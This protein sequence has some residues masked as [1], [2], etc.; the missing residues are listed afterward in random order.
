MRSL[1][2][3]NCVI[4]RAPAV[5][6]RITTAGALR[7]TVDMSARQSLRIGTG[8]GFSGD[9]IEPAVALAERGNIDFLVLECLAERTIALAQ[10]ERLKD[11]A[12]GFDP[13]LTERMEALL[14]PCRS[15]KIR[16]VTNSGAAHP[17]A[18]ARAA[19]EVARRLGLH[20]M[21]VAA[22]TG[23]D[24]LEHIRRHCGDYI[25][26]YPDLARIESRIISANVYL[27]AEPIARALDQG[28]DVVITGRVADPALFLAPLIH[29]FR[30]PLDDWP[31]LGKGI[32]TGHLMECA[33]Q[34]T[35]GYF[36]DPPLCT[37][38]DLAE[39]GFPIAEVTAAGA[40]TFS[41]V[42]GTG[43][44]LN[45]ATCTEQLLYEVHDPREYVTPDVVADFS[46]VRFAQAAPNVVTAEG[47]SGAPRPDRLK[48]VAAYLD[49]YIGEGQLSYAGP[50][51][52]A[53]ASL[54]L[55]IVRHRLKSLGM[56]EST[57]RFELI[58]VDSVVRTTAASSAP[59]PREVRI[60]V[61]GRASTLREASRIGDEVESLYTNGP[62]GGG[63]AVKAVRE[64]IGLLPMLIPR[65]VPQPAIAMETT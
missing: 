61:A 19:A 25:R 57:L 9:R 43:G 22:V 11:P 42:P 51:A 40:A 50:N 41:K 37:V 26:E 35:G 44:L 59:P 8:A 18:G 10:L 28:A 27:G 29:T 36:A 20:G 47:A 21:K 52:A 63:G 39:L 38:P 46:A 64:V 3:V 56:S 65:A 33:G 55:D 6:R 60:R 7:R 1:K 53:R 54:A 62:A 15:G 49:G 12:K 30:W 16:I 23:D 5:S 17:L 4:N 34:L 32:L 13:W 2:K 31:L 45:V 48:V 58:G 24:V 14:A